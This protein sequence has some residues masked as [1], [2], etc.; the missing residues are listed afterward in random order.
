MGIAQQI[1]ANLLLCDAAQVVGE[2]L[3]ILGGG[4]SYMWTQEAGTPLSFAVALDIIL[5]WDFANRNLNILVRVVTEDFEDVIL[6]GADGP[7]RAEGGLV[8][9]RSPQAR[10]GA[11]L[12]V[13]LVIPFPPL[14]LEPGGYVC[15]LQIDG[16]S[17]ARTSFQVGVIGQ[18]PQ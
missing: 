15:E 12:H 7:I 4:W 8:A 2:K 6:P 16:D 13:P 11:D 14:A 9:G 17:I 1:R 10:Q 3:Y 18:Q 5:P